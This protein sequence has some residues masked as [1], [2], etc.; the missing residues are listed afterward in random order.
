MATQKS[1]TDTEAI[2]VQQYNDGVAMEIIC[3]EA[4]VSWSTA[5]AIL[6]R[7][8]VPRRRR[9]NP[10]V[11]KTK[12]AADPKKAA[13]RKKK[14]EA[15]KEATPKKICSCCGCREVTPPNR[16]LCNPC[17]RGDGFGLHVQ[18]ASLCLG[19]ES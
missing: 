10:Y 3:K 8:N 18:G 2:V 13:A 15:K 5:Y 17:W 19:R 14:R 11:N 16:M 9:G 7:K 4:G 6:R 12:K 1:T